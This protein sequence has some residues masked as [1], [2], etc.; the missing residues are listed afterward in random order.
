MRKGLLIKILLPLVILSLSLA[1]SAKAYFSDEEKLTDIKLTAGSIDFSL[2]DGNG[3]VISLPLFN[4]SQIKPGFSEVKT[5]RVV[6]EGSLDFRYGVKANKTSGD[7]VLCSALKI[8]A[9]LD[10]VEKY[11][12]SLADFDLSYAATITSGE[13]SWSFEIKLDDASASVR[14]K[15]CNFDLV[16]KGWQ[17]SSDGNWG[18]TDIESLSNSISSGT[19]DV[20][21]SV[22]INEIMWMGSTLSSADEWIEFRNTTNNPIDLNGWKIE[23]AGAS[24]ESIT[25]SGTIPANGFFLLTNYSTTS[26]AISNS[27]MADQVASALSLLDSGERLVL[28]SA[29]GIVIDQTPSGSW[30]AGEDGS[31]KRSMERNDDPATGW[32]TCESNACNDTS[33]WDLEGNNYGTPKA[34]NLSENDSSSSGS[35]KTVD[36]S[37]VADDIASLDCNNTQ[38]AVIADTNSS[39]S[40]NLSSDINNA[41]TTDSGNKV[42]DDP[43]D[44]SFG[45]D[46]TQSDVVI[47]NLQIEIK[48]EPNQ[49]FD[50]SSQEVEKSE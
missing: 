46:K 32:H 30:V 26:S 49:D 44:N 12:G 41:T 2:R 35:E 31:F 5:I 33:F 14:D 39:F 45:Q 8:K 4:V 20:P 25:L 9:K 7:D 3:D 24:G 18:F 48:E 1:A 6:K 34:A 15:M 11:Y 47:T 40:G 43:V 23:N 16:F 37:L 10:G 13:D 17:T 22:V 28:V 38:E 29:V 50:E 21:G 36:N 27:I 19:W 42:A